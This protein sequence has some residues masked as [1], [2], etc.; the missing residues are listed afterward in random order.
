NQIRVDV[1][2]AVTGL[3]QARARYEAAA[4]ARA[5][6]QQILTGDQRRYEL[7]AA[8]PFQ[9]VQ[10]QRDLASAQNT[11]IQS[12]ANYTHAR[13]ALD[14]ALGPPLE[15]NHISIAEALRG[16]L[17]QPSILPSVLPREERQ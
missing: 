6:Q 1:Q 7:G 17:A 14:Q 15:V 2:N 3:E 16:Q 9:V 13:I 10:D 5:L 11:E 12:M 8:T 4:Q